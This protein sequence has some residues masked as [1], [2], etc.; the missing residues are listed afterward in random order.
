[1]IHELARFERAADQCTGPETQIS[2]AL[3]DVH[4]AEVDGGPGLIAASDDAERSD[5]E[6][7]RL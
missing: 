7:R 4:V 2:A 6:E 1:M 3:F 5:E